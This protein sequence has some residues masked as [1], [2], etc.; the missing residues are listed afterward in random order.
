MR[1]RWEWK[2]NGQELEGNEAKIRF[3]F[4]EKVKEER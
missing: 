2:L 1:S 4:A 3:V